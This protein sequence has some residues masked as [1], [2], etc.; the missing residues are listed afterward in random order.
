MTHPSRE[1]LIKALEAVETARQQNGL[2]RH[3]LADRLGI[4]F[5]TFSRWFQKASKR[6][7]S[8]AH[9]RRLDA[10]LSHTQTEQTEWNSA[11]EAIRAWW[12][13]Q[14]RYS[15]VS[16]LANEIGWDPGQLGY[17]LKGGAVPPRLV[18]ERLAEILRIPMPKTLPELGEAKRR[19]QRLKTLLI[20][21]HEELA[22]FRDG[23]E[24]V[25]TV[26]RTELDPFDVGY[27]SSLLAMLFDEAKF[28]RWL[29]A[30]TNRFASFQRK[31]GNQ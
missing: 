23:P 29:V 26:L 22:W 20:L 25:R 4:P 18:V 31:G 30:T 11:W 14:H 27:L 6:L 8:A 21:L 28:R 17:C 10:Y 19:S 13:T 15:S 24:A 3:Q 9:L 12:Q 2:S 7:P 1:R 16:V 5:E